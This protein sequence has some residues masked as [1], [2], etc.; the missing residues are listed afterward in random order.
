MEGELGPLRFRALK[1]L[2]DTRAFPARVSTVSITSLSL[3]N[4]SMLCVF[5]LHFGLRK[6]E[7]WIAPQDSVPTAKRN[8][9]F[10]AHDSIK[11]HLRREHVTVVQY[12]EARMRGF[13]I[14]AEI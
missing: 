11:N 4:R 9:S 1:V 5:H 8:R 7:G 3:A 6:R 2:R 13:W 10:S 12:G 14:S